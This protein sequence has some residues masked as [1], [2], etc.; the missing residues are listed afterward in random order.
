M[1][2]FAFGAPAL[3]GDRLWTATAAGTLHALDLRDGAPARPSPSAT[4]SA[5]A[6]ASASGYV[7]AGTGA[8]PN[9]PG[10][11]LTALG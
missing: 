8:A 3:A 11:T 1:P 7:L 10:E 6:I 2:G 4:P 5:S 9:L